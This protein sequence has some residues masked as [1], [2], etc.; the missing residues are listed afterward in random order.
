MK[1]LFIVI[2]LLASCTTP[3]GPKG[4][5]QEPVSYGDFKV[6][7]IDSCE[8]IEYDYGIFDQRVYSITHKGNCKF[9]IERQKLK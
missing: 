8:Y 2:I 3:E 9:C 7:I 6:K 5:Q 1:K 4:D